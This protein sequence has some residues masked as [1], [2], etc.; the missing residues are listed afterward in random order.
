MA[1]PRDPNDLLPLTPALFHVLI[2]LADGEQ[3][4]YAILKDV[5]QRTGGAVRLSTGTLYG[6]IKR[7]L[8]EGM[9]VE[10]TALPAPGQDERRRSYRLTPFGRAVA[11]AETER[12]ERDA[13]LARA[14][15]ALRPRRT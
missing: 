3:H 5:E 4:G 6:I 15:R 2:A 12:L 8:A 14:T 10:R 1:R 7:L 9:I 11:L 13:A